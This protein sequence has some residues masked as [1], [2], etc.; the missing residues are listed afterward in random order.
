MQAAA[1]CAALDRRG[2]H[3]WSTRT[4]PGCG[5]FI[6]AGRGGGH[7]RCLGGRRRPRLVGFAVGV[8]TI[9]IAA[10]SRDAR[11]QML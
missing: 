10:W 8:S 4:C 7:T 5:F 6:A 9:H 2:S 11:F 3:W 1:T